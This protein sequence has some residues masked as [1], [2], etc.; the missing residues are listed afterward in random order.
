MEYV[1]LKKSERDVIVIK[2]SK[3]IPNIKLSI[4][5]GRG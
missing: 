5:S 1:A 2:R 4:N 3:V